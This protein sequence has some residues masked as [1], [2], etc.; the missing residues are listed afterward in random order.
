MFTNNKI[1]YF[2]L[3]SAALLMVY[4][5][6]SNRV[7]DTSRFLNLQDSV[8][9]VGIQTCRSCH[10]EI[11]ESFAETGMGQSFDHAS[12]EESDASYGKHAFVYDEKSNFYYKPFF[13]DS[14]M[15]IMEY[16]LENGDTIHKR[17]EKISYIVGSGQHT[18]SHIIDVNGYIFQAPITYYTQD[19]RWD[20]APGFEDENLRF[21]R[22][23]TT[24]CIT[25]HNQY[26]TPIE[27]SLNKYVEMPK[28]IECER[29]HGPGEI[30]VKEKLA[31]NIIDTSKYI[32]Y[33]IVN[34]RHLTPDL[35][36]DVC[37]RCHLQG[38]AVLEDGKNFFDF[39]PGM[40]LSDVMNIFLPRYSN[41]HENFIM[42]SQ[43]DRLRLSNCFTM[44]EDL[45]CITC[46]NPHHS[47][48][49][50]SENQYN[51][52]CQKCHEEKNLALCSAPMVDR[53][54]EKDNCVSCHMPPSGSIDIPHVRI[55]DHYI[56]KTNVK[57]EKIEAVSDDVKKEIA[58]FLGLEILTKKTP[59]P[60]DMAKGYIA[61]HDKYV[62][63][64]QLLDSVQYYLDLSKEPKEKQLKT[65]IH[66]HFTKENYTKIIELAPNV[67]TIKDG[68]TAYRIG[69]AY[70][71]K[72][73]F[74]RALLYLKKAVKLSKYNLEFQEKLGS[75]YVNLQYFP[76]AKKVFE[77]V[78][79][80]NPKRTVALSNLGYIY[81]LMRQVDKGEALYDKAI[82]LDPDYEQ[83]MM[84]KVA[85]VLLRKDKSSAKKLINRVLKINPKN[86]QAQ[87][88]LKTL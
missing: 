11:Y 87:D 6:Q 9:Y 79:E 59:T 47:V 39:K 7:A 32:D 78:L 12:K 18:N 67:E 64:E 35:Q 29:C 57:N 20:I 68:W 48:K 83:A 60:L 81:V 85:V 46:H 84:N 55:T 28:G 5:N 58:Q 73:E 13:R 77:F 15:Y 3:L 10:P 54:K 88:V 42:A 25:C 19:G 65:L 41:S 53:E 43:A 75:T 40:K 22:L 45:S 24:E 86:Q 71:Q 26:P 56:S 74:Q 70:F 2:C 80:E 66:Y 76:Q 38:L 30:H 21:E 44:S 16:R 14:S 72:R 52:T 4:C 27:G 69:E 82:A 49:S 34:P 17:T 36:M 8:K 51:K 61:M 62:Q 37:Q 31:G 1:V 63:E 23:L 50:T 33:T